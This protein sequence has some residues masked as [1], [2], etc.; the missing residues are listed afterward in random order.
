M[1]IE[2]TQPSYE[3]ES[4]RVAMYRH[5]TVTWGSKNS[6]ESVGKEKPIEV[7]KLW[8]GK[9]REGERDKSWCLATADGG[10]TFAHT[11]QAS[12]FVECRMW[13]LGPE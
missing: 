2:H 7:S 12:I 1:Y 5:T 8:W 13:S 9:G 10:R 11:S 6:S 4:Y 3:G